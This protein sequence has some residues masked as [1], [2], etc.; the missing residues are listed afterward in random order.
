MHHPPIDLSNYNLRQSMRDLGP[1]VQTW[2][3]LAGCLGLVIALIDTVVRIFTVPG[4]E[5]IQPLHVRLPAQLS[6]LLHHHRRRVILCD[7]AAHCAGRLECDG[8]AN[9]RN[10]CR[11]T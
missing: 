11:E 10:Y 6:V 2:P 8:S 9:C 5:R 4:E 3:L 1:G 7:G